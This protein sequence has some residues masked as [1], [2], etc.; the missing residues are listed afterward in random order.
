M[1]PPPHLWLFVISTLALLLAPGP[2]VLYIVT[3]SIM[4]GRRAGLLCVFGLGCGTL[5]YVA[6]GTLGLSA[7]LASSALL[8]DLLRFGGAAYLIVLGLRQWSSPR[9]A[10]PPLELSGHP[11]GQSFVQSMLVNV[12]NPK[13][14]LYFVAFLPTFVDADRGPPAPQFLML[15]LLFVALACCT[16]ALYAL[17]SSA[18]SGVLRGNARFWALETQI[19]GGMY[20][21]LG[22]VAALSPHG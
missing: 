12:L 10:P 17:C 5:I 22:L 8:M 7:L 18:L 11:Q 1:L 15:G 14:A 20:M 2:T 21:G 16:N 4:H 3:R 6:V 9:T 19:A 13:I